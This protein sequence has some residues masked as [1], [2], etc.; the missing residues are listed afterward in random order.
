VRE[1]PW[2]SQVLPCLRWRPI[3]N[4]RLVVHVWPTGLE[5]SSNP[6]QW[7]A[8]SSIRDDGSFE[9]SSLP[10]GDLEVVALCAGFLSTNGPGRQGTR[11]PQKYILGT[12]DLSVTVGMKPTARL[13]VQVL[14]PNGRPLV[15]AKVQTWPNVTYGQ[16]SS[17]ILAGDLYKTSEEFLRKGS[18]NILLAFNNIIATVAPEL[19]HPCY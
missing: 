19:I 18:Q 2:W 8:W 7:H 15:G 12:N 5:P 17:T 10:E 6:L 13:E 4:G 9:I 1:W 11:A 16:W 3:R 14:D